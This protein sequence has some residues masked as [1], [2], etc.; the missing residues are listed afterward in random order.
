MGLA[1]DKYTFGSGDD[2]VQNLTI[3]GK[4]NYDFKTSGP[5]EVGDLTVTGNSFFSGIA[6]FT[7]DVNLELGEVGILTVRKRLDV[8]V[9]GT[10]LRASDEGKVGIGSQTPTQELDVVGNV[11]VSGKV[12]IGSTQPEIGR[13]HV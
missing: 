10:V 2:F 5:L 6:T 12:G 8:G 4:L 7:S 9:G 13:A 1:P 3:Y 11:T